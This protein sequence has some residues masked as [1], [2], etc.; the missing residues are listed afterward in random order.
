MS[1]KR[2]SYY[3]TRFGTNI[4]KDNSVAGFTNNNKAAIEIHHLV[5]DSYAMFPAFITTFSDDHQSEWNE[6]S[7]Y[8]RMD[9]LSTFKRT[10]RMITIEFD[11][12][13]YSQREA[14]ANLDELSKLKRFLYPA[15]DNIGGYT[16]GNALAISSSPFLRVKFLNYVSSMVD[17]EKGLLCTIKNVNFSPNPEAGEY[18]VA[19]SGAGAL[20]SKKIIPKL[21]KISLSL[22]VFH[23]HTMGWVKNGSGEYV[24]SSDS[25]NQDYPYYRFNDTSA[26]EREPDTSGLTPADPLA[27]D[28]SGITQAMR[29]RSKQAADAIT[30]ANVESFRTTSFNP[31]PPRR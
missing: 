26:A 13:S 22:S 9:D 23:E 18:V 11:V 21:F 6:E 28:T 31:F 5:S 27:E 1:D 19:T 7:V 15:Y 20:F 4:P 24:F 10:K 17:G 25:I 8:G 29:D 14:E 30:N 3:A 2:N 16:T 12:P